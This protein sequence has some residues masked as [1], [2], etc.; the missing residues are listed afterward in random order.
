MIYH[1]YALVNK[2]GKYEYIGET[3]NPRQ[4][5]NLHVCKNGKFKRENVNM[6]IIKSFDNKSDAF[7]YQ[8]ELQI[9]YGFQTDSE[10]CRISN[11]FIKKRNPWGSCSKNTK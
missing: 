3:K 4:R 11:S 6:Q 8:C 2:E 5:F 9:K 7:K 1:V 10:K